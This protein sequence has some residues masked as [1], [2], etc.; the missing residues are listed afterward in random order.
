[1]PLMAPLAPHA[2]RLARYN[3]RGT[4]EP[5]PGGASD[6]KEALMF[7]RILIDLAALATIAAL[8]LDLWKHLHEIE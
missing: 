8:V 1:M 6:A 2:A 4:G 7:E 3:G 5:V